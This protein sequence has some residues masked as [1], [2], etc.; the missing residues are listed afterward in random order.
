MVVSEAKIVFGLRD[1]VRVRF[2]CQSC[3]NEVVI[4]LGGQKRPTIKKQC[5]LCNEDWLTEKGAQHIDQML[6]DFDGLD[7][8]KVDVLIEIDAPER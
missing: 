7:T 2:R 8:H 4:R 5:H 6:K 3:G 1:I